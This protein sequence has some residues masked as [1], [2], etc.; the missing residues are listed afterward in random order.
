MDLDRARGFVRENHH[1]VLVTTRDDGSPQTSPVAATVDGEGRVVVSTRETA[2][3]T[4]NLR[5]R[6]TAWLCVFTDAFF[7]PWVQVEGQVE[8]VELPEAMDPLIDYYRR[9][10]GEHDDWEAYR[11]AMQNEQ[12]VLLRITPRRAGPD[13]SG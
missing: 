8:I 6:P 12:R 13:V 7:G 9:V 4:R 11:Q 5:K 1:A 2:V 3:K 10:A